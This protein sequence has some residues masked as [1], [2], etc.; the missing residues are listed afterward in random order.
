M[1]NELTIEVDDSEIIL[2]NG[3]VDLSGEKWAQTINEIRRLTA[4]NERL[5]WMVNEADDDH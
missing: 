1:S 2:G 4:E 3:R 5:E